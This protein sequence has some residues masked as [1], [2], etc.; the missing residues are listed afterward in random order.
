MGEG[1][2]RGGKTVME[3]VTI[4]MGLEQDSFEQSSCLWL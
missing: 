2:G 1:L 3:L 4:K